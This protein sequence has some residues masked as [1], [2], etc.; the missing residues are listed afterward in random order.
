ME[1]KKL[2][3]SM[4][5]LKTFTKA[6]KEKEFQK[7]LNDYVDEI[8]NPKHKPEMQQYLRQLEE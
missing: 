4:N 8:S 7:G 1:G 2:D 5:E 6:M 3:M